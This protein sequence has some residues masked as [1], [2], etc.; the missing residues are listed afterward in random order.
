MNTD[1]I[2]A[3]Y[4]NIAALQESRAI[5]PGGSRERPRE[6]STTHPPRGA[7]NPLA[8]AVFQAFAQSGVKLPSP[9]AQAP[10]QTQTGQ[11]GASVGQA[12]HS[13]MHELFQAAKGEQT[14]S[15]GSTGKSYQG[16]ADRL[17]SLAGK[18]QNGTGGESAGKLQASF[19]NLLNTVAQN[20]PTQQNNNATPTLQDFLKNLG[21]VLQGAGGSAVGS[22]VS[23]AA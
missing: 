19:D 16:L 13:F 5:Q 3:T 11:S 10:A 14:T 18:V 15:T 9:S 7:G 1:A 17:S 6:S 12:M 4:G 21:N 20:A 22:L 2:S 23:T 8:G